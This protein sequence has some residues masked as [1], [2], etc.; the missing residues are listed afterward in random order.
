MDRHPACQQEWSFASGIFSHS[1]GAGVSSVCSMKEER[2][3]RKTFSRGRPAI[4]S[5]V[6]T[7]SGEHAPEPMMIALMIP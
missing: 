1:I 6:I 7:D 3:S 2:L 5:F 4:F